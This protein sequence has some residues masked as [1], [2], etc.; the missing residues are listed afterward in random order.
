MSVLPDEMWRRILEMG[1]TKSY[2]GYRG[3][4]CISITCRRLNRLANEDSLWS[5]L[6]TLDFRSR[7]YNDP[8]SLE[9][10]TSSLKELYRT[11]FER[12]KARMLAAHRRAVLRVESQIAVCSANLRDIRNRS[13]QEN[14]KMK[15]TLAELKNLE[16]ARQAAV[17][18]NVWQ[19]HI[20]RGWQKQI[21]GQTSVPVDSRI[22]A[23]E[24]EVK[25]CRQQI[26]V[27]DK[28]YRVE[29][30]RLDAAK[31]QLQLLK[32][33]PLRDYTVPETRVDESSS[34]RKKLKHCSKYKL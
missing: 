3:L 6:L 12:D 29:N 28:A 27:Y 25:L 24:M 4:C 11:R 33:H 18:L 16:K 8:S 34:K 30:Q 32:Y 21:V 17:A 15:A 31:E 7:N 10:P 19:P 20:I 2:F 22:T 14:E 9:P 23:L 1:M 13:L 5:T 26:K